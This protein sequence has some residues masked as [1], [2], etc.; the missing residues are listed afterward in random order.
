MPRNLHAVGHVVLYLHVLECAD[1]RT[2]RLTHGL[3][4]SSLFAALCGAAIAVAT[5]NLT[6]VTTQALKLTLHLTLIPARM[7]RVLSDSAAVSRPVADKLLTHSQSVPVTIA[8]LGLGCGS[9]PSTITKP[10]DAEPKSVRGASDTGEAIAL[11]IMAAR[12]KPR[13]DPVLAARIVPDFALKNAYHTVHSCWQSLQC[14]DRDLGYNIVHEREKISSQ[15]M[16]AS[17]ARD[18]GHWQPLARGHALTTS[19]CPCRC[20]RHQRG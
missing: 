16:H 17:P 2:L 13:F 8:S 14:S 7:R 10:V 18:P 3:L 12:K 1:V 19:L 4:S 15:V 9:F 6:P 20:S 11:H 5:H